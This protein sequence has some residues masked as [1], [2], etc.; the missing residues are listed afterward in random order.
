MGST[1]GMPITLVC[2]KIGLKDFLTFLNHKG[3]STIIARNAFVPQQI[4]PIAA[5]FE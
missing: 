1:V 4:F 3:I 5:L 2:V